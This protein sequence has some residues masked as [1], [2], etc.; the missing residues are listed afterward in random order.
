MYKGDVFICSIGD[1]RYS[2][3]PTYL[4][5]N[6]ELAENRRIAYHQRNKKENIEGTRG[7]YALNILWRLRIAQPCSCNTESVV[8]LLHKQEIILHGAKRLLRPRGT[9]DE[10]KN[11]SRAASLPP[12]QK[13]TFSLFSIYLW[14]VT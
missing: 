8:H 1:I 2:D 12:T 14:R 10:G 7:Y 9:C 4:E 5:V 11:S 13:S 6:K 3:Y